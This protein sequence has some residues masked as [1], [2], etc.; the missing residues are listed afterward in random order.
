MLDALT[1]AYMQHV[2]KFARSHVDV[3]ASS[4][5]NFVRNDSFWYCNQ[6][7][8]DTNLLKSSWK[9]KMALE[10]IKNF[11]LEFRSEKEMASA[12]EIK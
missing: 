10:S 6:L 2:A 3:A 4:F 5:R 8:C 11:S 9:S 12:I 7:C 1:F